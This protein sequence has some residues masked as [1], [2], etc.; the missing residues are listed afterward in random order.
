MKILAWV[1]LFAGAQAGDP[2]PRTWDED[3]I[4]S[5]QLPL[6]SP[7][8]SAVPVP[9]D[10]YYRVPVRPLYETHPVYHPSR[11]PAGYFERLKGLSPGLRLLDF[12]K[13]Q[14]SEEWTKAGELVFD[15]PIAFDLAGTADQFRDP[16]FYDTVGIPVA[17]DGTVPFVRYVIREKG[18]VEVGA[19]ACGMCHTRVMRDGSVVKGA[20][21]NFPFDS[22]GAQEFPDEFLPFARRLFHMVYD[23]PWIRS[24]EPALAFDGMTGTEMLARGKAVPPG[25]QARHGTGFHVPAQ[26]PDLIGVRER[27]YLDKTGLVRHRDVADLMRYAALNQ[28]MDL[29]SRYGDFVPVAE[30][31]R[32]LPEPDQESPIPFVSGRYSDAQ[33]YALARY[34]YS[35]EPP[36]NPNP[37]DGL[38]KRGREVF[39]REGCAGCHTPP[40]YT[41]NQLTPASGFTIPDDHRAKYDIL[42]IVVST[43][44]A[45]A[46]TTRRGTG[47]Y[48]VPSLKGVWYRGPFQHSGAVATLEDW[49][50][51]ARLRDDYVPTGFKGYGVETK[52]V[53]GHE[54]GLRLSAEDTAALIAFLKTL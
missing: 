29:Y 22:S 49:F 54:F 11:E 2:V 35:L 19:G 21:G 44:P 3:A 36:K 34:L 10:Y 52:A 20:Q 42:E 8:H 38:S 15:E 16:S 40:E 53:P 39:E 23:V 26:I 33:L 14:N 12:S 18:R 30:D 4:E 37:V 24:A 46:L 9:A 17:S 25:V 43:D 28:T 48:K 41:N 47:Y 13:L 50:D 31:Y 32:T 7:S 6:A 51:P 27:K 5:L 1:V 45:L